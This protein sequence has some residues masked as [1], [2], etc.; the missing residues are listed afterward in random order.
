MVGR[1]RGRPRT[2]LS[3]EDLERLLSDEEIMRELSTLEEIE[4]EWRR[5]RGG[6]PA[7]EARNRELMK[8]P[9]GGIEL[10]A[11]ICRWLKRELGRVPDIKEI[12]SLQRQI[13]RLRAA[14][15]KDRPVGVRQNLRVN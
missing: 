15:P 12:R 4:R 10:R 7:K 14:H 11:F 1:K 9:A 6:A 13:Y 2:R 3:L 5:Q 8:A